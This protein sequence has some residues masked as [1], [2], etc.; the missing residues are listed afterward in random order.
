MSSSGTPNPSRHHNGF[1]AM[2]MLYL[3]IITNSWFHHEPTMLTDFLSFHGAQGSG[4]WSNGFFWHSHNYTSVKSTLAS[5]FTHGD[6]EH[7]FSNMFL[8]WLSGKQ[9]FVSENDTP[10]R[11]RQNQNQN[12][13]SWTSPSAFLWIYVGSQ[14]LS[15]AG[16]RII[17]HWLDREWSKRVADGR[18]LW[19]WQW[20]PYSWRDAWFTLSNAQQAVELRAWQYTPIIGSSAAV[21]GV[22]GAHVYVATC[23][24]SHPAEMDARAKTIWLMKIGMEL[25]KTPL[26]LKKISSLEGGDNIDHASHFCGFVGGFFLAFVWDRVFAR[27]RPNNNENR[28]YDDL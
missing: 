2:G 11:Q 25:A 10:S 19:S 22:V 5:L 18:N 21:F 23:S 8:L 1:S 14:F 6:W 12:Q 24:R 13:I 9:L 26:S 27:R 15:V 28:V 7:V 17:C 20:V 3:T 4:P 16:C